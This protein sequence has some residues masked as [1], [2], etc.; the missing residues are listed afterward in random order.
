MRLKG[1]CYD[2]GIRMGVNW[3]PHFDPKVVRRELEVLGRDL[4]CN[5]VRLC[6]HSLSRLSF[7]AE[8]ALSQGLEVWLSPQL[9]NRT[10]T[11]SVGYLTRAAEMLESLRQRWPDKVV[12]SVGWEISLFSRGI[13]PGRTLAKRT[14]HPGLFALVKSG[15]LGSRVNAYLA[16]V[17]A[18]VRRVYRGKITYASLSWEGVDWA[19]FD[20]VGVDHY[21]S[22]KIEDRYVEM[23]RP[24]FDTKKP[25]VITEFGYEA[26]EKGPMSEGFLDSAGLKPSVI[27]VR[28]QLLHQLP[29]VGRFVRPHLREMHAR[30]EPYQAR[31]LVEQ[32]EILEDAGVE[33]GFVATF[34]SQITPYDPDPRFDLDMASPSLVR[35]LEHG[36]GATYPDMPWEPK[37]SFRAV[38]KFYA[39]H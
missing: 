4:H 33:G 13:V 21:R 11:Q 5:A 34:L 39:D 36:H 10:A 15:E 24:A 23:L 12:L 19:P 35:Y 20:L 2:V 6:G 28:S 9:W 7:A 37:E 3:R 29:M 25:V 16:E 38:A 31:K 14:S 32:L 22:T 27:D 17:V 26:I 1:V 18:A 8:S 30:D